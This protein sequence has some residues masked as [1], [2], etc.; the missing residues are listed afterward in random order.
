MTLKVIRQPRLLVTLA[1]TAVTF[2]VAVFAGLA[3]AGSALADHGGG[4]ER[5]VTL[6]EDWAPFNRCPV[7]DPTMLGADGT[8][9]LAACLA[10]TSPSGSMKIGNLNVT[11]KASDHQFGIV[12][13]EETREST[14]VGP[15]GGVLLDE[16]VHLPGGLQELMCPSSGYVA[17]KVCR[18]HHG[19]GWDDVTWTLESAGVPSNFVLLGGLVA[20]VPFAT[21]PVKVH[22]QNPLL[23][24]DCYIGTDA[25]PIV[26]QS[27]NL[28]EPAGLA[29]E[30][31][32]AD[33][34]PNE[35]GALFRIVVLN[36]PEGANSFAVPA[37]S[38]CGHRGFFNDAINSKVGLPSPA[39]GENS[40]VFAEATSY[41]ATTEIPS[42]QGQELSK[43]WHFGVVL[44]ERHGG[45]GHH[46]GGSWRHWS[47]RSAEEY[48]WHKFGH[49][50]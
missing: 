14:V 6:N 22:L 28:A 21:I 35:T 11:T 19:W 18:H 12:V 49:R 47:R 32:D 25:E 29:I 48:Y 27:M 30:R 34:T 42:N 36:T 44:P 10:E 45:S 37:A 33:G 13:N 17:W 40:V 7:D 2:A 3:S 9:G 5:S 23:G 41:I 8:Q 31:F 50:H 46:H 24:D 26:L 38:G 43:D 15:A 16:P 4:W 39:G 1:T 20:G